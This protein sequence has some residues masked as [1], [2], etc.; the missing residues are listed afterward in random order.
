MA[1]SLEK[2]QFQAKKNDFSIENG[3]FHQN[4]VFSSERPQCLP[5][6]RTF[7][8]K[9]LLFIKNRHPQRKNATFLQKWRFPIESGTFH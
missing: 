1:S 8:L 3:T 5:Q 9:W 7:Q 6:N 2:C 4:M